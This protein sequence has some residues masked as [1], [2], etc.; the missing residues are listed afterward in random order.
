MNSTCPLAYRYG[1]KSIKAI[2]AEETQTL[3]VVGGLYGNP[4]AL[5]T[6]KQ[7][8]DDERNNA[9]LCFNGDF[10]WFDIAPNQFQLIQTEVM[11]YEA[12]SGNVEYELGTENYSGG[13]GC[14]Y[15]T[16]V[17]PE[18]VELSDAIH[19]RL[20]TT[21]RNFPEAIKY[22]SQL[23]MFKKYSVA[24]L[25]VAVVHGDADSL[26]GWN[27][28]LSLIDKNT[29]REWVQQ[30]FTLAEVDVFASSHT[31]TALMRRFSNNGKDK[32][33]INN[34]SAG[35]PNFL[36]QLHGVITR[37]SSDRY[38][39]ESLASTRIGN[40]WIE[41]LPIRYNHEAWVHEFL[42]Q[43]PEGSDAYTSYWTKIAQGPNY[44]LHN[45]YGPFC[46]SA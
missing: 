13:C 36:K 30:A 20:S 42:K 41:S 33:V 5:S 44:S 11:Q 31:G 12:I 10:H 46:F 32:L 9:K 28:D 34:G 35:A 6:I 2:K 7:L 21:A 1:A 38:K 8:F 45:A 25:N 19:R 27:F 43:W 18:I 17:A 4:Y 23:S 15:P 26:A 22:F 16:S 39:G 37:I 14:S 40:A 29:I 3:Y 24:G